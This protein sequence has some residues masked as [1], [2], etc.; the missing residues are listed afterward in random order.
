MNLMT[1]TLITGANKGLGFEA[2]RRLLADG[3]DVW[4]AARD[5]QRG[6]AAAQT[7]GARFVQL[8]VTDEA[9]VAAAARTVAA[10]TGLD[11]L[12]NNAGISGG[13]AVQVPDLTAADVHR[14]YDTNTL[15]VVRVSQAFIPLLRRSASPV[16]VN[17][18]SGLG[19]FTITNQPDRTESKIISLAYC[20][21][22]AAVNM[23]TNQYAKVYP[24]I[25]INAVDPGY[26]ATDLNRHSGPQTVQ[27]GTDAIVAMAN[28]G[29]DGPTGTFSDRHGTVPW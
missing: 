24:D 26:T 17:V 29:P 22:K 13:L 23:L 21:S 19:S 25:R 28:I 16:I 27:E 1:T 12:I 8:D 14:V 20:S 7:L 4:V 5:E 9:S 11:V 15:G 18:S 2:A 10:E 6:R 3:H